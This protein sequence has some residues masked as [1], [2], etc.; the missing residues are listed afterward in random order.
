MRGSD[1][2]FRYGGDEF[3]AILSHADSARARAVVD[4]LCR[5]ISRSLDQM[6]NGAIRLGLSVGV[7]WFPDDGTTGQELV[8]VADVVGHWMTPCVRPMSS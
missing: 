8:P 6:D 2:A 7:A 1:L 5:R 3:A 4:R